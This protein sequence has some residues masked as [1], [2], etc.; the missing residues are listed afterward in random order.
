MQY[1]SI[2]LPYV[3]T[4][5]RDLRVDPELSSRDLLLLLVF[6]VSVRLLCISSILLICSLFIR[7]ILSCIKFGTSLSADRVL[8]EAA[9][10]A[11][12]LALSEA[13]ARVCTSLKAAFSL[14]SIAS[15][16]DNRSLVSVDF[17]PF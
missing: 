17:L 6:S 12:I 4:S 5:S 3:L 9:T 1:E 11:S 8:V 7:S 10:V 13:V 15:E 2:S 14:R 16:G